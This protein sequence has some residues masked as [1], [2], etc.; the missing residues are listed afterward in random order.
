MAAGV[1]LVAGCGSSSSDAGSDGG[2][3][4]ADTAAAE[5]MV[6]KYG[7]PLTSVD[8]PPLEKT[9]EA[10]KSVV[11]VTNNIPESQYLAEGSIAAAKLLGW[12][13]KSIVYDASSPTGLTAAFAQAVD[14][15]PDGVMTNATNTTD[16]AAA[17]KEFAAKNIPVV[18]SNTTDPIGAP[19]IANVADPSQYEL[20][21]KIVASYVVAQK[22]DEASVAMFNIPSFPILKAYEDAFKA[23]FLRLCPDCH[24]ESHAVQP[25]DIGTKIPSQV[26]SAIQRNPSINFASMGFGAV[27]TGV[28]GA[29][30]SAGLNDTKIIGI[31]PTTENLEATSNGTE[32]MWLASPITGMGW[33]SVDAL[34]R[35][36]NGE[37]V[38]VATKAQVPF[39]I[40]TKDNAEDYMPRA[41]VDGGD[42]EA[43]FEPIWKLN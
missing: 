36:F 1:V 4:A 27:G 43:V 6:A 32:D 37:D 17:A 33:K 10:G 5:A 28:S 20:A 14:E 2:G 3:A 39:V 26:V 15:A 35:Y 21:G 31:Q 38:E 9:P 23:E 40:I 29:L 24:Y 41:E 25:G 11:F 22:G 12:N 42:Y 34:A 16:Y 18:T 8:L 30:A 13:A 7:E 19:I